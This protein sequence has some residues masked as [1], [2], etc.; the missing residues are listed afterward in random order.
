MMLTG[1][2]IFLSFYYFRSF[3]SS[4]VTCHLSL[5]LIHST[6]VKRMV[7]ENE[8][9]VLFLALSLFNSE[10][11][12]KLLNFSKSQF[13]YMQTRSPVHRSV[14]Q[15][16]SLCMACRDQAKTTIQ[17]PPRNIV[18]HEAAG[19]WGA[20]WARAGRWAAPASAHPGPAA[21]AAAAQ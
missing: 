21:P 16:G 11:L 19:S 9:W 4:T 13:P 3:S 7:L 10:T 8:T 20:A 15:W 17:H 12:G 14:Y 2:P 18:V 1:T 5:S 6:L